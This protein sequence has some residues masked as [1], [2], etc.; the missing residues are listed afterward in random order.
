MVCGEGADVGEHRGWRVVVKGPGV[1]L[2]VWRE[3]GQDRTRQFSKRRGQTRDLAEAFA[4][5]RAAEVLLGIREAV[6]AGG[7]PLA[8]RAAVTAELVA[9]YLEVLRGRR[10]AISTIKYLEWMFGVFAA[11]V[12][13]LHAPGARKRLREWLDSL[14]N[15]RTGKLIS[16][17]T[18][19]KFLVMIR[20][21]C[22]WAV[23]Q[24]RLSSDLTEGIEAARLDDRLKPQFTIPELRTCL[25]RRTFKAGRK[26]RKG[27]APPDDLYYL[28]F[29]VLCYAGLRYQEACFLRW[30]DI[31]FSAG[32]ILVRLD[33][34]AAIKRNRERIVPLQAELRTLLE[35]HQKKNGHLFAGWRS[36]PRRDFRAFCERAGVDPGKRTPHSLRHSYAGLMTATGVPG[37]LLGAYLGHTN[38]ATTM[39]Y[40]KLAARYAQVVG[41][42]K[43][44]EFQLLI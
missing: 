23:K 8:A 41:D 34:G 27:K 35:P 13:D 2:A 4:R 9:D 28:L 32:I 40:T 33:S 36:N 6:I 19:N 26:P 14:K 29:A 44:G 16:P 15:Q 3:D 39:I 12:P 22:Q 37:P 17:A 20:A 21:L 30:E 42:W 24:Q 7:V 1:W 25:Q 10:L 11:A 18:R 43:R 31:D 38:A 5:Q